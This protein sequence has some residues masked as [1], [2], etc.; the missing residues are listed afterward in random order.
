V[1]T[2]TDTILVMT[3]NLGGDLELARPN[4]IADRVVESMTFD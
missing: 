2:G 4:A 1:P 3:W